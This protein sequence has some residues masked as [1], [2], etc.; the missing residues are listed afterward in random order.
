MAKLF[1]GVDSA[2]KV[3]EQ[4]FNCVKSQFGSPK[5]WGRYLNT[6]EGVSVGLT[7]E[8]RSFLHTRGVKVMPI[9]NN[10]QA[11]VGLREGK[12]AARNAIF[13]AQR[14]GIAEGTFIF[15]NVERFFEVD[16]DW[17]VGWVETFYNSE[18]RPGFYND[19]VE[20]GFSDAYCQAIEQN[21]QVRIQSVL[22]SAEPEP[23]VSGANNYPNFAP[24]SPPCEA[25]VWA[26]Q[27]GR[28]AD[29][30]PIDT[31]LLQDRLFDNLD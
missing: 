17:L 31:V 2:A 9:Y 25:N 13:N 19:P 23:G 26:W 21:E 24:E 14:I 27:Y 5:F 8:E 10:F 1:W 22:W 29:E 20:G 15:A 16:A 7:K 6:I 12:V 3:D 28:D 18:Y 30:C 4:L 11:S